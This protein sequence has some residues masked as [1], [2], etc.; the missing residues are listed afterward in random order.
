MNRVSRLAFAFDRDWA[1]VLL[2][3]SLLL[4]FLPIPFAGTSSGAL[5]LLAGLR[6]LLL[7]SV[8]G[9]ITRIRRVENIEARWITL[10]VLFLGASMI[11]ALF[12]TDSSASLMD[13]GRQ[14]YVAVFSILLVLAARGPNA[15]VKLAGGMLLLPLLGMAAV[16]YLF[17]A[18]GGGLSSDALRSFKASVSISVPSLAI[19]PLAAFIVLTLG[20]SVPV[21]SRLR[22]LRWA[23][24]AMFVGAVIISG[25]RSTLVALP[26]ALLLFLTVKILSKRT[27]LARLLALAVPLAISFAMLT[28]VSLPT[29][30]VDDLDALTTH[31]VYL[32]QTA[33]D[34]F[35]NHPLLG[36]GADT[37]RV[38][39][40]TAVMPAQVRA[41]S[42]RLSEYSSGAYHNAYLAFLAERGMIV[43]VPAML[44]MWFVLRCAFRVYACRHL[45]APGDREFA[46]FAPMM[47]LFIL[48]RQFAECSGLLGYANGVGDF[49]SF[50]LASVIIGLAA[51]VENLPATANEREQIAFSRIATA[52]SW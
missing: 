25:A 39:F 37:W 50:A 22:Y 7:L 24:A 9:G 15:R 28:N 14:G 11:S 19:N 47:V 33:L 32:W 36:A 38:N 12:S 3:I 45:L 27:T 42:Y 5:L 23:I 2:P 31:R 34:Q 30:S 48:I 6:A 16:G 51:D 40:E 1:L 29:V 10:L 46:A 4:W 49:V 26:L 52:E 21:V 41:L 13:L 35:A 18:Y 8:C 44:I 20:L 17:L 43:F